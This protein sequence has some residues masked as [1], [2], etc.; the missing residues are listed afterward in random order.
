MTTPKLTQA[1]Y[2]SYNIH[3]TRI[4]FL[5]G[6]PDHSVL[7]EIIAVNTLLWGGILNPIVVLDSSTCVTEQF[8]P[9]SYEEGILRLLKEFDPDILINYSDLGI[10]SFLAVFADRTFDRTFLRWN[11]W[12]KEDINF[13]LEVWPFLSRYWREVHQFLKQP[14]QEFTYVDIPSSSELKSYLAAR[15]GAYPSDE[16]YKLLE[17][18]FGATPSIYDEDFRRNFVLGQQTFPIQLTAYGLDIPL[19][20]FLQSHIYFLLDPTNVFDLVDFWNLRATGGRV[21][22]LPV[23][24][25]KDFAESILAFGEQGTYPINDSVMNHPTIVK[26]RSV[27]EELLWEVGQW[28]SQLGVKQIP[29]QRWVPR[30]GEKGYRIAP[31]INVRPASASEVSQTVVMTNGSGMLD[32]AAPECEFSGPSSSQHWAIDLQ[33]FGSG[34]DRHTWRLPWPD[35]KCDEYVNGH[36]GHGYQLTKSRVSKS[37]IVA[38]RQGERESLILQEPE[39]NGVLKAFLKT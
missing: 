28:I 21:F 9:Y 4:A 12:G 38:I 34:D 19:P 5:M 30:F 17:H 8:P 35:S 33:F 11:P 24:H 25:Y 6:K 7:E 10:P 36:V 3:P 31:E 1:L 37:G 26:G 27:A 20:G 23:A 18:T 13:F 39:V 15:Y 16:G 14:H 32:V 2:V 22:A 29:C